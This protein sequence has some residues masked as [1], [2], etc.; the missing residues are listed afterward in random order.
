MLNKIFFCGFLFSILVNATSSFEVDLNLIKDRV[1]P[2]DVLTLTPAQVKKKSALVRMKYAQ[3]NSDWKTCADFRKMSLNQ[4]AQLKGWIW[5]IALTCEQKAL[6]ADNQRAASLK[7]TLKQFET[8]QS[9]L[10]SG[11]WAKD[12]QK[13]WLELA[14]WAWS[15]STGTEKQKWGSFLFSRTELVPNSIEAQILQQ[16]QEPFELTQKSATPQTKPQSWVSEAWWE[17]AR[18]FDYELVLQQLKE[19]FKK[20][21]S[22]SNEL[23][24]RLFYAKAYLWTGQYDSAKEQFRLLIDKAPET[25]EGLE[26]LFRLGLL[27]LRLG[28]PQ[29]ATEVFDRLIQTGKE[30]NPLTTRYWRARALQQMGQIENFDLERSAIIKQYPFTYFGLKLKSEMENG[31]LK[32]DSFVAPK[33]RSKWLWPLAVQ[34]QWKRFLVL[35]ELGWSWE[36]GQEIANL[37]P[38]IEPGPSHMWSEFLSAM[39]VDFLAIRLA[40]NAQNGDD[41]LLVWDFQRKMMPMPHSQLVMQQS[42]IHKV[43]PWMI[44]AIMRQESAFNM[45]AQSTSNAFGLMQLIGPTAQEVAADLKTTILIPE[46]LFS[47]VKNI[48]FGTRYLAKMKNEFDGHWPLAVAAYNAGPSRLKSWIKLRKDT[49]NLPQTKSVDWRDE[50]WID[51]MPWAETQNYVKAVMR[52]YLLYRMS[53]QNSWT[54]PPVFWSEMDSSKPASSRQM[55]EKRKLTR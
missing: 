5:L 54:L 19:Y 43:E 9:L 1:K 4:N 47:P 40:Q 6:E 50:L 44:W 10:D 12:L 27:H 30:K 53:S 25:E 14:Q 33:P 45:R 42:E 20:N 18:K 51:E 39:K 37:L 55:I 23:S 13:I 8:D 48:A 21:D 46:E 2:L 17:N 52:N 29:V 11:P 41:R 38:F 36:A 49:E 16:L 26:A 22:P 35:T 31:T 15:N 32:F 24:A 7:K 28:N 3:H 34:P